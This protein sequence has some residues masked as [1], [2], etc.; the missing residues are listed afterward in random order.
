MPCSR[1][2]EISN[3]IKA[4]SRTHLISE[5]EIK[6]IIDAKL[7]DNKT[8]SALQYVNPQGNRWVSTYDFPSYV[9]EN[10]ERDYLVWLLAQPVYQELIVGAPIYRAIDNEHI[11]PLARNIYDQQGRYIGILS[12]DVSLTY[13]DSFY[14][15]IAKDN[16][17][18]VLLLADSGLVIV[19][20]NDVIKSGRRSY[21]N[22]PVISELR[23][24]ALSE[25]SLLVANYEEKTTQQILS[26]RKVQNFPLLVIFSRDQDKVLTSWYERSRN[27]LI[28]TSLI[29]CILVLLSVF[30]YQ[31]MRGLQ[32]SQDKLKQSELR[33]AAF[34]RH[35][36]VPLAII[37]LQTDCLSDANASFLTQ[38]HYSADQ[39]IGKTPTDLQLWRD[40]ELRPAYLRK[41]K[42]VNFVDNFEA[43]LFD[44]NQQALTCLISSRI[45]SEFSQDSCIFSPINITELRQAEN[46]IR[47]LNNQLESRIDE[48]TQSLQTALDQLTRMQKEL[49]HSEKLA[50]LGLMMAGIAHELNT[51][52]GNC[53]TS[54]STVQDYAKELQREL[55]NQKPRRSVLTQH[56][57]LIQQGS[58]IICQNLMRSANL[59]QNFKQITE[60]EQASQTER[61][62][63][64][65]LITYHHKDLFPVTTQCQVSVINQVA[66]ELS[67][68]SYPLVVLQVLQQLILNALQ[69]GFDGRIAG[70]IEINAHFIQRDEC[71]IVVK[72][73]GV[74]IAEEFL[75]KVFDP[76][77]TT[78]LGRGNSGLG[79]NLVHNLVKEVLRGKLD[80]KSQA[81]YG[82]E[83]GFTVH[84]F[85]V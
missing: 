67:L 53:L 13:F 51:P 40:P 14:S 5:S 65:D 49:I 19:E 8:P 41:L 16:D 54:S 25:G 44:A 37:N 78:K 23:S 62:N 11:L 30:L 76:F 64:Y 45:L 77:Y 85:Q 1:F 69:H 81:G 84:D 63:L 6:A 59:I 55:G 74:G 32:R 15:R 39:V 2:D 57:T 24:K 66:A 9:F 33:F 20:F 22:H 7:K 28:Q 73:N 50:A 71:R 75:G 18:S 4:T 61:F 3:A 52:I 21:V 58:E 12:A 70:E 31:H 79:L 46:Q 43:V 56:A 47:E 27:R 68:N 38:F 42:Q 72:D 82:T 10:E 60:I 34:F 29:V 80:L 83:F 17:S 35:S 36:P 48:R 26:Y